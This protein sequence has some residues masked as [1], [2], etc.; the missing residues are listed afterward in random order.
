MTVISQRTDRSQVEGVRLKEVFEYA[1]EQTEA[2]NEALTH[3][4]GKT[5][6]EW[7][8]AV[9]PELRQ[10]LKE[11]PTNWRMDSNF[12]DEEDDLDLP[13]DWID[14]YAAGSEEAR[15]QS[16]GKGVM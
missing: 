7:A 14:R 2:L 3:A 1:K 12:S 8:R 4:T 10:N 6:A 11:I 15:L 5:A 16:V 9:K 13:D